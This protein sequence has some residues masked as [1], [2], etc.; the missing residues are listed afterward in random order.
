M[1]WGEH[2]KPR[3]RVEGLLPAWGQ[4]RAGL[5]RIKPSGRVQARGVWDT[6]QKL[7]R[8]SENSG[9][10]TAHTPNGLQAESFFHP[11]PGLLDPPL[12]R[13]EQQLLVMVLT[14]VH[15]GWSVPTPQEPIGKERTLVC[16]W[17]PTL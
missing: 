13:L 9:D 2:R 10:Q 7:H 16:S 4:E 17:G 5:Q 11:D 6:K 12:M 14:S 8:A 3:K 1:G 15:G